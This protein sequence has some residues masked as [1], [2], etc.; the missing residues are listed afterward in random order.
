MVFSQ[1]NVMEFEDTIILSYW[2]E[3]DGVFFDDIIAK[4]EEINNWVEKEIQNQMSSISALVESLIDTIGLV[5][6]GV[7]EQKVWI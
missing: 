2:A 7:F 5:T 4:A 1:K 6:E 3:V